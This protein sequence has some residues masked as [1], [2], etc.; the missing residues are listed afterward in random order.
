LP[1]KTRSGFSFSTI[2]CSAFATANGSTIPSVLIK[3]PLSA[4][5]ARA[6][7]TVSCDFSSPTVI[8]IISVALPASL[9]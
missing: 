3:I 9:I 1:I 4:P 7:L 2:F 6:F 8:A 5:T